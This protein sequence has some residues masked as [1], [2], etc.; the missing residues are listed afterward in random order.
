MKGDDTVRLLLGY[1][2]VKGEH[3]FPAE[4][5]VPADPMKAA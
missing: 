4:H 5:L 3:D 2:I 1:K